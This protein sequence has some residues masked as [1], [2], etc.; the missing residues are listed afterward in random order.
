MENVINSIE[1]ERQFP[2]F[3]FSINAPSDASL[4][5]EALHVRQRKLEEAKKNLT[6]IE[7]K[8]QELQVMLRRL[9]RKPRFHKLQYVLKHRIAVF[10]GN[11]PLFG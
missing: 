2:V 8:I 4:N 5:E 3:N 9:T 10:S 1:M 7:G 11:D 6:Q